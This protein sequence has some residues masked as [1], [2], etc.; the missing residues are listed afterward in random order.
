M[1]DTKGTAL[2]E[3]TTVA[4]DD[5]LYIIDDPGGTPISK[6]ATVDNVYLASQAYGN[7]LVTGGSAA[8]SLTAATPAK[9]ALFTADGPSLNTT[10]AHASDQITVDVAGVYRIAAQFSMTSDGTN[11]TFQFYIAV[12]GVSQNIGCH[13]LVS[14][15]SDVGSA[16]LTGHLSLSAAD[17]VTINVEADKNNDLTLVEAQLVIAKIG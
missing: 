15:G 16:S 14:T 7:I 13:R 17:V 6:K 11:V 2:T 12:G 5:L 10:P 1:A 9:L 8:Q 3:L 4:V